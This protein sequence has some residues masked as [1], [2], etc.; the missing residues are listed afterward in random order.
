MAIKRIAVEQIRPGM[1]IANMKCGWLQHPFVKNR[2]KVGD[3]NDIHRLIEHGVREVYIDTDKGLDTCDSPTEAEVLIDITAD[4]QSVSGQDR[5]VRDCVPASEEVRAAQKTKRSAMKTIAEVMQSV[6][7][8]RQIESEKVEHIVEEMFESVLRNSNVLLTLCRIRERHEHTYMHSIGVC[9]LM[10]AFCQ[11]RALSPEQT[12][13]AA[14]GALLHDIGKTSLPNDVLDKPAPL[15]HAELIAVREHVTCGLQ[16]LDESGINTEE[17]RL[18]VGQHHEREN[19]TGYP[20]CLK[21]QDISSWGKMAAIADVYDAVTS[22]RPYRDAIGPA[23]AVRDLYEASRYYFDRNLVEVFIKCI[24]IYPIG[25]L[26]RLESGLMGFVIDFEDGRLL[27]PVVR[28]VY[29][30]NSKWFVS[31]RTI[32]LSARPDG[33]SGNRIVGHENASEWRIDPAL[34]WDHFSRPG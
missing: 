31:P 18:V 27:E 9:A 33:E 29:D 7:L 21:G 13:K 5:L 1:F 23:D 26:V 28:I 25:T 20:A 14:T 17:C 24:G 19:G 22:N 12:R 6:R 10:L 8:G 2:F 3:S 32:H 30:T 16:R 34:F 11:A 4:L 15:D